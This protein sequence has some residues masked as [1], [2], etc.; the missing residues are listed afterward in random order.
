MRLPK[1][2][3]VASCAVA[4]A[5]VLYLLW[6]AD[7]A[8]SGLSGTRVTGLVILAL[9]IVASASAV[10]PGFA[11]LLHGNRAY[12]TVTSLLGLGALA[13][14]IVTLWSGDSASLG[15]LTVALVLL[16]AVSTTHHVLL[17]RTE[18]C[19]ECGATVPEAS[20]EV[21]GYDLVRKTRGEVAMETMNRRPL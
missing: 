6:L 17:A 14:G 13:A 16:W 19:P 12:L 15:A 1:R 10:V 2:D 5:V 20:C 8:E 4:T 11:L 9:G 3:I 21:C 18:T 7:V